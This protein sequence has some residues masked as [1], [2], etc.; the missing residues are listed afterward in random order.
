MINFTNQTDKY[1][2]YHNYNEKPLRHQAKR[3]SGP[4]AK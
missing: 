4:L 3:L 2:I 1:N